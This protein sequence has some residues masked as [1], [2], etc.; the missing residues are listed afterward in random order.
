MYKYIDISTHQKNVDYAKVK[1]DG[2]VGVLLR[3]GHTG[4]AK[5]TMH[6][7]ELF[8]K[9]YAGFTKV[10]LPIGVY[11]FSRANTV[12]MAIKEAQLTLEFMLGKEIKLPVYFD[13]EDTYYQSKTS[14]VQL[15]EIAKAYCR[16]IA[17]AG[18]TAGIYASKHWLDNRLDMKQLEELYEVWVAQYAS[19]CTYKRKY[20]IW[21]YTSSGIV[22]GISGKVD[23]NY[24]Y[25]KYHSTGSVVQTYS[26][27]WDDE[28]TKDLQ[29][30]L[31]TTADKVISGQ[32]KWAG[33]VNI[34]SVRY[35]IFGSRLVRAIQ[36][37]LGIKITGQLD[38]E[39]IKAMQ[40]FYG[41]TQDGFISSNSQLVRAMRARK[42][43]VGKY[44]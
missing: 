21:Q 19:V 9:H 17:D 5:Q 6:K 24:V 25:K 18:Y 13:T 38:K 37:K 33:I 39:T 27:E 44:F 26:G 42:A 4:Y 34:K 12:A 8:E 29:L 30:E 10:G 41:T 2:I 31:G 23:V 36:T 15:T 28:L 16:I 35:G 40:K 22:K 20:Q 32:R 1:A 43:S 7:D 11:W 3:V 14:K